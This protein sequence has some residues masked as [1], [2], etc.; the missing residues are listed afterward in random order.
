MTSSNA[1]A[2]REAES[3]TKDDEYVSRENVGV[4]GPS[5][6]NEQENIEKKKIENEEGSVNHDIE[7]AQLP[8][9]SAPLDWCGP[10]DNEN[11]LNWSLAERIWIMIV[12]SLLI[13]AV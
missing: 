13:L 7:S 2:H 8:T 6:E 4:V 3:T 5:T 12:L 11:P 10:D 1:G 9:S